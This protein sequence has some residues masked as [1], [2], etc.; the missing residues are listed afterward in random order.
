MRM[1]RPPTGKTGK[2]TNLYLDPDIVKGGRNVAKER[3]GISLSE[4][5][6]RL[7]LREMN[8]KRGL[9]KT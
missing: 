4:L 8:L 7:V 5:I 6:E 3:Y 1:A 2:S 9:L